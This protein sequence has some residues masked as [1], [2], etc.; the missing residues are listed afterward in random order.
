[1]AEDP[2]RRYRDK[3]HFDVTPEPEGAAE[4]G[5]R[6][7]AFVVQKHA[8]RRLHYDFRLEVDGVLASWAV[9]KGP[10]YDPKV[11]RLAV[12]VE[13]HPLD[14]RDFEGVIPGGQY[15][16]GS[17]I[18]WDEGTYRNLSAKGMRDAIEAGHVSVWMDG[19][20]LRGGW[21]LTR[22]GGENWIMVKR[23]DETVDPS[24]DI[25]TAAPAS[26]KTGRSLD[27][28]AADPDAATWTRETAT[29]QPPMLATLVD[30]TSFMARDGTTSDWSYERKLDGLRC[31]AVR[32]G[33][34]VELW[35]RNHNSFR[36]RFPEIVAA[37]GSLAVENFTVD[38]E[39]VAF[40]GEDFAGFGALQH[41]GSSMP[42]VF[43]VFDV[44]H[45]LGRDTRALSLDDRKRLL[46]QVVEPSPWVVPVGELAGE[47]GQLL[48]AGCA[49]GWEG[50]IAK[51]RDSLYQ[52]GRSR[53]W[54]KLK[55]SASQEL[56]I[57]GWTEPRGARTGFGALLVGYY[58]GGQ[59]RYAGKVGTGFNA[60][61]LADL[62]RRLEELAR[63][64][65]PFAEPIKE[66]TAHWVE[67]RLVAN[68]GFGEWTGS[69]RLRHP[70]FEGLRPD[71]DAATVERERPR[72]ARPC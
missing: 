59:L 72:V 10:S 57:G 56:V 42:V 29:W 15:G 32:N 6:G 28:V 53:D 3:R 41:R 8:A 11:K 48:P 35:S 19:T 12:H 34:E 37:L 45:L 20:K 60:E 54:C 33:G 51:R 38:G 63:P 71:K 4:E 62:S 55:C 61:T 22:T 49:K 39:L 70:R 46:G 9:P 50:L 66:R 14:Y 13:D 69:G 36:G 7:D 64:D 31:V 5:G 47:P 1:M 58:E 65:P 24:L 68:V 43:C 2:L 25:E 27:D 16:T 52:K 44:L 17:V 30:P 23:R 21:A 67:P 40:D 18:V 26:V